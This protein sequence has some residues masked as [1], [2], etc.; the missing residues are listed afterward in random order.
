MAERVL[1]DLAPFCRP[2]RRPQMNMKREAGGKRGLEPT[3][4]EETEA[5][6]PTQTD[7]KE[8]GRLCHHYSCPPTASSGQPQWEGARWRLAG[9]WPGSDARFPGLLY[10]ASHVNS[11]YPALVRP[12][13]VPIFQ[14]C[15]RRCPPRPSLSFSYP[16]STRHVA[17]RP[18]IRRPPRSPGSKP[19]SPDLELA[20]SPSCQRSATTLSAG[21]PKVSQRVSDST[22]CAR[23]VF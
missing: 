14:R 5:G 10:D 21:F 11:L 15:P 23:R 9:Y 4:G 3:G 1:L 12:T 2:W 16:P 7:E 8:L 6:R 17:Q 22:T 18:R 13:R 20:Y 19:T